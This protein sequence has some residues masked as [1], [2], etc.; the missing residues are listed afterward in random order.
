VQERSIPKLST[1]AVIPVRG[2]MMD[3]RSFPLSKLGDKC[4]IDWSLEAA[5]GSKTVTDILVSTPDSDVQKYVRDKYHDK[6]IVYGWNQCS[7]RTK[8]LRNN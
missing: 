8:P 7:F 2:N 4:L 5:L 3:P 6:V 1:L